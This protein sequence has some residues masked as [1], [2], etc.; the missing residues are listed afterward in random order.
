MGRTGLLVAF[1]VIASLAAGCLGPGTTQSPRLFV[2]TATAVPSSDEASTS[3]H[4]L[5]VG[6]VQIPERLQRPQIL[7][8]LTAPNEI[9]LS[10][11]SRW[12]EPLEGSVARVLTENLSKLTATHQVFLY[13]WSKRANVNLQIEVDVLHFEGQVGEPV[14]L[15]ARWRL[16][17]SSGQELSTPRLS[18]YTEPTRAN[19]I[20]AMVAAMSRTLGA[21]SAEIAAE[22]TNI[23]AP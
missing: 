11:F 15:I 21:L 17:D 10:D 14:K 6:P 18:Q 1:V 8:R 16:L 19:T 23:T 12:A 13:P 4:R 9:A 3:G 20:E 5:G 2:L 22:I 7:T